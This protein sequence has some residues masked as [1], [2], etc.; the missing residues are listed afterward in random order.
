MRSLS[1]NINRHVKYTKDKEGEIQLT[2][3]LLRRFLEEHLEFIVAYLY[4]ADTLQDYLVKRMQVI[5]Q[6]LGKLHEDLYV[7]YET[8][9]NYMLQQLHQ[10]VAPTQAQ[11]AKLPREWLL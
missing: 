10:K 6:K 5:L 3:L 2:L 8:D 9:V 7:E 4:R 1:G 11:K